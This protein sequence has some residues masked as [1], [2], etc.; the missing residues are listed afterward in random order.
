M[1]VF[2][3]MSHLSRPVLYLRLSNGRMTQSSSRP[4]FPMGFNVPATKLDRNSTVLSF[5][6]EV[7]LLYLIVVAAAAACA[8]RRVRL[9]I[10]SP[11]S[12]CWRKDKAPQKRN[13]NVLFGVSQLTLYRLQCRGVQR[14]ERQSLPLQTPPRPPRAPAKNK[15]LSPKGRTQDVSAAHIVIATGLA[16]I[17]KQKPPIALNKQIHLCD[18]PSGRKRHQRLCPVPRSAS[19]VPKC[20]CWFTISA[21]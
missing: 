19:I 14:L 16:K 2:I 1:F 17:N 8:H 9:A 13:R 7:P 21:A 11:S 6:A 4:S 3:M 10:P 5:V 18:V 20:P 12:R 15:G